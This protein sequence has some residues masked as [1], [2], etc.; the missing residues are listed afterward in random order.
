ME[1]AQF[2]VLKTGEVFLAQEKENELQRLYFAASN[3]EALC[4]A[5]EEIVGAAVEPL[6]CNVVA[7]ESRISALLE[8]FRCAGFSAHFPLIRL[9]R[10]PQDI[11]AANLDSATVPVTLRTAGTEDAEKIAKMFTEVFDPFSEPVPN[12]KEIVAAALSSEIL[13]AAANEQLQGVL[14][15]E[16]RGQVATVRFWAVMPSAAGKGVA[17]KLMRNLLEESPKRLTRLWVLEKNENAITRYRHYGF[18]PD[19]M[20]TEVMTFFPTK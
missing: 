1:D 16:R 10:M 7:G 4:E 9:T 5:L 18:Q 17:S 13:L 19:G 20:R 14:W 2:S 12:T 6:C 8:V 11:F 15:T 3:Y